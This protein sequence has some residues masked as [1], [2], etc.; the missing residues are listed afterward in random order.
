[1]RKI[2]HKEEVDPKVEVARFS[3]PKN[4]FTQPRF[5]LSNSNSPAMWRK[6]RPRLVFKKQAFQNASAILFTKKEARFA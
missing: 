5:A 6:R 1:M 4:A 2:P 3:T